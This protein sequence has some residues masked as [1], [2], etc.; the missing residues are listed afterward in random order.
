[1]L[2]SFV[3]FLFAVN[4]CQAAAILCLQDNTADGCFHDLVQNPDRG[5]QEDN[6]VWRALP[7]ALWLLH[8]VG[9]GELRLGWLLVQSL[10]FWCRY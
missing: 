4:E 7:P 10:L 6:Q 5:W 9:I 3:Q 1:M 2:L 8:L